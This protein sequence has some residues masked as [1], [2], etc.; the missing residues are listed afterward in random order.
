MYGET[1]P[2]SSIGGGVF[3][4]ITGYIDGG[5]EY[6]IIGG[7]VGFIAGMINAM[8]TYHDISTVNTVFLIG[9]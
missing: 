6:S 3:F 9:M 2:L 4:S 1:V 5:M 8:N 7:N